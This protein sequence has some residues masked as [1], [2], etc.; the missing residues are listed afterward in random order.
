M[1]NCARSDLN[2]SHPVIHS[3]KRNHRSL[4]MNALDT[5]KD[6]GHIKGIMPKAID[7]HRSILC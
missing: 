4:H 3:A 5:I 2:S 1:E 6:F 7:F